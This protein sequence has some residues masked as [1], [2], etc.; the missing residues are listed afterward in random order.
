MTVSTRL[1]KTAFN[2]SNSV[3][4][5]EEKFVKPTAPSSETS[6][7]LYWKNVLNVKTMQMDESEI[8]SNK[9]QQIKR[10]IY[11]WM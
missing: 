4:F 11:W 6:F 3:Q 10:S 2:R 8:V 7:S 1:N 5:V 9:T